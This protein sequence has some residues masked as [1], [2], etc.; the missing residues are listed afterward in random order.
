[1][2]TVPYDRTTKRPTNFVTAESG[3]DSHTPPEI[4]GIELPLVFF[5]NFLYLFFYR[6]FFG[7]LVQ[8]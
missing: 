1:M 3:E 6:C 5:D 7:V 8:V 2:T 4:H